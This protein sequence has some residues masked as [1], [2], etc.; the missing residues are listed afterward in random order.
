M[1]DLLDK[2]CELHAEVK[3]MATKDAVQDKFD[4]ILEAIC[5]QARRHGE[6]VARLA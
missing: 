4:E 2:M 6:F 1:D 5:E 3:R